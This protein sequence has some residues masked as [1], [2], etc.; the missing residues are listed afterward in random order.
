MKTYIAL[1]LLSPPS[2]PLDFYFFLHIVPQSITAGSKSLSY[3]M[4]KVRQ[5]EQG[6]LGQK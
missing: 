4:D 2:F 6:S 5:Q 3:F 1:T